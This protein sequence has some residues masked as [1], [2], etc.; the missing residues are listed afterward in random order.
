[1]YVTPVVALE[2]AG[3][4]AAAALAA[5]RAAP[6]WPQVPR[7][8]HAEQLLPERAVAGDERARVQLMEHVYNG[9]QDASGDLLTTVAAYVEHGGSLE[10][11]GR[12]LFVHPNTVRYRLKR[13]S[14]ITGLPLATPRGRFAAHVALVLGR[15]DPAHADRL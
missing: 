3:A 15:L 6:A 4:G 9:L 13:A 5:V 1:V 14:E 12:A 11:A 10:A 8:V 7:P 2:F